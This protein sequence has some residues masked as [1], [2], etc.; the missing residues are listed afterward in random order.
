VA[1]IAVVPAP[2]AVTRPVPETVTTP[3]FAL[4]HEIA[5]PVNTLPLASRVT[6]A[7]CTV[8]PIRMLDDEGETVTDATGTPAPVTVEGTTVRRALPLTRPRVAVMAAD[9]GDIA[10]TTPEAAT[11]ATRVSLELQLT[12]Q[13]NVRPLLSSRTA[14]A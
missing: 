13:S 14:V 6:A 11:V 4:D 3:E 7:S 5:R 9:P 12:R 10:V 1:V 2:I 8:P